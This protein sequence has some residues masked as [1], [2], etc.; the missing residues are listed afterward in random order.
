MEADDDTMNGRDALRLVVPLER[1]VGKV[2]LDVE[3]LPERRDLFALC[4]GVCR[5]E[6][7]SCRRALN[8]VICLFVPAADEV[9]VLVLG[10][11]REH[12]GLLL[13]AHPREAQERRIA[14]NVVGARP[15]NRERVRAD[16]V[17][18]VLDRDSREILPEAVGD[19]HV[20][21]MI[22][23]PQ[24]DLGDFG[25][26]RLYF[27][28][29]ELRDIDLAQ[30][31]HIEE[32][33]G[34]VPVEFLQHIHFEAAQ[35]AVGDEE[36][37]AASASGV[38]ERERGDL[39]V[40]GPEPRFLCPA[41]QGANRVELGAEGVEEERADEPQDVLFRRVVRHRGMQPTPRLVWRAAFPAAC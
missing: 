6:S 31:R 11:E 15:V 26:E 10:E 20:A 29:V 14:E 24:R 38:E 39:L 37:V 17:R 30:L 12:V 25:G 9:E 28:S 40:E 1:A 2:D 13:R 4:D 35:L 27:Y 22:H 21:E 8:K 5:Y 32:L 23:E 41:L 16:D 18:G 19:L 3:V 7:A 33:S 34:V 36:E